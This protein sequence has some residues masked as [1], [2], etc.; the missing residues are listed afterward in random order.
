MI[1]LRAREETNIER[2]TVG[3]II[4]LNTNRAEYSYIHI[5]RVCGAYVRTY[6]EVRSYACLM[7]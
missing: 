2:E 6:E 7:K 5:K 3:I 4:S 1:V